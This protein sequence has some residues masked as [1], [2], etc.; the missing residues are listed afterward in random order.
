MDHTLTLW[1]YE[2]LKQGRSPATMQHMIREV[3]HFAEW[4]A[5]PLNS[6]TVS[7]CLG[8]LAHRRETISTHASEYSWRSL[9]SYF[10]FVS[11]LDE[12]PSP[13]AKIKCP[14]RDEAATKGVTEK[15]YRALMLACEG[16]GWLE[17]R[18]RAIIALLYCIGLRR[19]ELTNLTMDAMNLDQRMLVVRKSKTGK[20][21]AVPVSTDAT[22]AM[23][24]YLRKRRE[25]K[26]SDLIFLSQKG[27]MTANGL[28]IMLERRSNQAGV[29]VSAH[30]FRRAFAVDW[31]KKG[32]SQVSLMSICGWSSS[33]CSHADPLREARCVSSGGC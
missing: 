13:M 33:V 23:V 1:R 3:N 21:R 6:A 10:A 16:T 5:G 26:E 11:E 7:D 27:P 24:K 2:W 19:A 29:H 22:V 14:R 4:L 20:P 12:V 9:R 8:Y 18:D 31:L 30:M 32:G 17:L 28:R 25:R 15:E